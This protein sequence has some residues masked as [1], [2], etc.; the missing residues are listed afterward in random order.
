[1]KN[2][3]LKF[4]YEIEDSLTLVLRLGGTQNFKN[5]PS[6]EDTEKWALDAIN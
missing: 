3:S 6:P 2:I 4:F 1:M 5:L